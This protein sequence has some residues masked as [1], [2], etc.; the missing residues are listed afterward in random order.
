MDS[1]WGQRKLEARK[2]LKTPQNPQHPAARPVEC[3]ENGVHALLG[4]FVEQDALTE[5]KPIFPTQDSENE[6]F[7]FFD[8]DITLAVTAYAI[9]DFWKIQPG[10]KNPKRLKANAEKARI[11]AN[12]T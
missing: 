3:N 11:G 9:I 4:T 6:W 1:A 8:S 5:I 7:S 12:V 2:C 10:T